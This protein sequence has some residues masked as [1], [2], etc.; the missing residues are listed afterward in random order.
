MVLHPLVTGTAAP[1]E[2]ELPEDR[3]NPCTWMATTM[4]SGKGF[5]CWMK[6]FFLGTYNLMY[7]DV[8]ILLAGQP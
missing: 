1:R 3:E 7:H 2:V 8:P 4:V 5:P 6:L